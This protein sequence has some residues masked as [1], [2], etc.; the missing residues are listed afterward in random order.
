MWVKKLDH[1]TFSEI[2]E[3]YPEHNRSVYEE[4]KNACR[5][6]RV[7]P[8]VGAGLS[9][10]CGYQ[11]WPDVLR[12]LAKFILDT[13]LRTDIE[14]MIKRGDLLQ[15]AQKIQDHYP[16]MLKELQKIIGYDKIK[17]CGNEKLYASAAYVLP[18]LFQNGFV[19]TTNFDRVLEE[20]Y[21]RC[22]VKFGKIVTPLEPDILTQCRQANPHCLFK[23]HGDI[24]P[25]VHDINRLVF[26]QAQY[27]RTYADDSPLMQELPQWFQNKILLFLGCSLAMD[28]TMEVLRKVT[29]KNP[30]LEHYAILACSPAEMPNRCVELGKLG[31]SAV[32]YPDG[33]HEAVRVVLERLLEDINSDAYEELTRHT[34]RALPDSNIGRRFM[35]NADYV[36]FVG[37][38]D[39]LAQLRAFCES[40]EQISWWAVAG[41][42][43]IGKSR[44]VYEFTNAQRRAGWEVRWL[45]HSDY[46]GLPCW[47]PPTDPCIIVADDVQAHLRAVG[48]WIVSISERQRSEKLRIILLERQG[49]DL[50]SAKWVDLLQADSP[51]NSTIPSKCYCADFLKLDPLSDDDLKSIM[52]DFA[53]ASGKPL[54]DDEHADR[55]LRTL[56]KIDNDLQRPIYALAIVDAWCGGKD[57]THWD[58]EQI[59][60]AL[61]KRELSFYYE[62]LRSLSAD[63]VTKEARSELERLLARSCMV[64]FLPLDQ[65]S[66]EEYPKLCKRAEKIDATLHDLLRQA[67][68][69]R[70]IEVEIEIRGGKSSNQMTRMGVVEAVFLDCPDL[71]KEYLVLQQTLDKG[72]IN[73]LFPENWDNDPIHL[74]FLRR[75]FFDYSQKLGENKQFWTGFLSGDPDME[76]F[77]CIYGDILFGITAYLPKIEKS[78]VERL[79]KLYRKFPDSDDVA[80][81]YAKGLENHAID[82]ELADCSLSVQ[83]LAGL[84]SRSPTNEGFAAVYAGGLVSLS[85]HQANENDIRASDIQ[86]SSV[87]R[88]KEIL[89]AFPQ[90]AEI[91]FYCA[92]TQFNLTLKQEGE[93]LQQGVAR[94]REFL[95]A[96]PDANQEFQK[97]LDDYL[98]EHPDHTE[99]YASLRV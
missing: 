88:S 68:V 54:V 53:Q 69:L 99:R 20:V 56:K 11:I 40:S 19:M 90:N 14:A 5:N 8:F 29:S 37:R 2:M 55:L 49:R 72:Q 58:K 15:A 76:F 95:I 84:Y 91:Q 63:S 62:R 81:E 18:Y 85:F 25:E 52:T 38:E 22:H 26:T 83:K 89:A 3:F 7:I 21:D 48:K 9:V 92:Q 41:P 32:F 35:Y 98:D 24:G 73:L 67:G 23:L 75:L 97:A 28:K 51:Y 80:L 46:D 33:K 93:A 94:L 17:N 60:D 79:E 10:F 13:D 87:A 57:P 86:E 44:L 34:Q 66:D 36:T 78:A 64:P 59:L 77:A 74:L 16:R 1:I 30:G 39:E 96:H 47:T 6:G 71:I 31:I 4:L 43:G 27:D 45:G 65:I 70:R 42:G 50:S 12:R 82:Q 61:V